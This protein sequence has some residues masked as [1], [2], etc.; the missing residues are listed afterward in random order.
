MVEGPVES[1]E[2]GSRKYPGRVPWEVETCFPGKSFEILVSE[3]AIFILL[4]SK[5]KR[6]IM[7]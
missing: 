3:I 5:K 7:C 4:L 2:K 1:G 6:N